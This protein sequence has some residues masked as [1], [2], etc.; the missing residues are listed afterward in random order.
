MKRLFLLGAYHDSDYH[1]DH[2][3]L[4]LHIQHDGDLRGAHAVG[5]FADVFSRVLPA[6]VGQHTAVV[7]DL[8]SPGQRRAQLGPGDGRGWETWTSREEMKIIF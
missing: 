7:D 6:H 4:T 8:V 5:G 2:T 1:L 3:T